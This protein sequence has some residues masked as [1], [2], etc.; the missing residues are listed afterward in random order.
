[1]EETDPALASAYFDHF[2]AAFATFDGERVADLF[3]AP[4][5]V[6]RSDGSLLGLPGRAI[7]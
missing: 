2:V 7:L 1:M 3:A 6:L 4:V 5:V